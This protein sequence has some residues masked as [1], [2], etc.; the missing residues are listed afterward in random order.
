MMRDTLN[1]DRKV[2]SNPKLRVSD[3]RLIKLIDFENI[4]LRFQVNIRLYEPVNQ[5]TWRLVF[6][7]APDSS[8]AHSID[9]GL[10]EGHC[11]YIKDLDFLA[12]HWEYGE[13]QQR[14]THCDNSDRHI[15]K[16]WCT[17]GRPK[18]VCPGEKFERIMNA[19]KKAFGGGNTQF[20]W[21]AC[22]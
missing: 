6:G 12:N 9:I 22:R 4:A 16:K 2:Y 3:V 5:L 20:S 19:S 7:E 21:K 8:I 11:F 14:F 13:F 10:Y 15:A 18:L 17:F 1:L